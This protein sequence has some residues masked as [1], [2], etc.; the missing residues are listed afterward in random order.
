MYRKFFD[1]AQQACDAIGAVLDRP[2]PAP[3]KHIRLK[4]FDSRTNNRSIY[5]NVNP[6][7]EGGSVYQG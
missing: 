5:L 3:G 4:H 2:L 6:D 1:S 7:G